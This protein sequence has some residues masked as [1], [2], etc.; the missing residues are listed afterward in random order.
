VAEDDGTFLKQLLTLTE[1]AT[2]RQQLA[3]HAFLYAQS[4]FSAE[5]VYKELSTFLERDSTMG[6]LLDD[7]DYDHKM[8]I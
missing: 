7:L 4:H 3:N 8:T 5:V 2:A 6:Y 1:S